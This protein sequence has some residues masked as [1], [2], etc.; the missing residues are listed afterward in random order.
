MG[1]RVKSLRMMSVRNGTARVERSMSRLIKS[2]PNPFA[3]WEIPQTSLAICKC[4]R[5]DAGKSHIRMCF[6]S[7]PI[8]KPSKYPHGT[9][10]TRE[11]SQIQKWIA[12]AANPFYIRPNKRRPANSLRACRTTRRRRAPALWWRSNSKTNHPGKRA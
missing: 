7:Y 6:L 12:R 4:C 1:H 8:P 11:N 5:T 2:I 3:A 10:T 9:D